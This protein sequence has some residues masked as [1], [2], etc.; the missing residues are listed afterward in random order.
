MCDHCLLASILTFFVRIGYINAMCG[1]NTSLFLLRV[2]AIVRICSSSSHQVGNTDFE[3]HTHPVDA[4]SLPLGTK[5]VLII[6]F[7]HRTK[8]ICSAG[9]LRVCSSSSF[10]IVY[11]CS[12]RALFVVDVA[13][14][15][16]LPRH[17]IFFLLFQ[18]PRT[19]C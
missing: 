16:S 11:T 17:S 1:D 6:Y 14:T 12:V 3:V 13:S 4:Q 8:A 2:A 10:A 7:G 19:Y 5:S 15:V 18:S 9:L